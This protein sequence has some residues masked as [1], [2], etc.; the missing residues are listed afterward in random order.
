VLAA[1]VIAIKYGIGLSE[2]DEHIIIIIGVKTN[3]TTSLT[4]NALKIPVVKT[5]RYNNFER[6]LA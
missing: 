4:E 2:S 5:I 6:V 3:T 1:Q